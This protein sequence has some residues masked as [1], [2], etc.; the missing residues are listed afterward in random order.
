MLIPA[1]LIT[2]ALSIVTLAVEWAESKVATSVP[3]GAEPLDQ[4]APSLQMPVP[5]PFVQESAA[6]ANRPSSRST[7]AA[8]LDLRCGR[9]VLEERSAEGSSLSQGNDNIDHP[10]A[11]QPAMA[12]C[13]RQVQTALMQFCR[14]GS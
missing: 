10:L 9:C 3:V 14:A 8:L 4:L 12:A 1:V 2:A 13:F 7:V 5:A 6:S 11:E